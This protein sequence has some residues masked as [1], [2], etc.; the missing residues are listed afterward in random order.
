[1][2]LL[3]WNPALP[4]A[5]NKALC[6][7]TSKPLLGSSK[8]S[9]CRGSRSTGTT[10]STQ[11]TLRTG[12]C[13]PGPEAC[14]EESSKG[15]ELL[16]VAAA[17]GHSQLLPVRCGTH[18]LRCRGSAGVTLTSWHWQG[19][20]KRQGWNLLLTLS[21]NRQN[22]MPKSWMGHPGPQRPCHAVKHRLLPSC[23]CG[24]RA[25]LMARQEQGTARVR[26]VGHRRPHQRLGAGE[27][28]PS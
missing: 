20:Q 8:C 11:T 4:P 12:R 21:A 9:P 27:A 3:R 28:A 10:A 23:Q 19:R 2:A 18:S 6:A 14:F 15:W 24:H 7:L 22:K 26:L 1:M 13:P 16:L 25:A 5:H 17:P